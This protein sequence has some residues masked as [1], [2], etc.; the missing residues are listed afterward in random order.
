MKKALVAA[1]VIASATAAQAHSLNAGGQG[2]G[3]NYGLC[4]T[5]VPFPG[6]GGPMLRLP[7]QRPCPGA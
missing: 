3:N 1:L 5:I 4:N 7:L 6:M 2:N